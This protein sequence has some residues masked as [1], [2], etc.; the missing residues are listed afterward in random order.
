MSIIE[1]IIMTMLDAIE[2]IIISGKLISGNKVYDLEKGKILFYIKNILVLSIIV[3]IL[4]EF[5]PGK[6]SMVVISV[7]STVLI[8]FVLY[9]KK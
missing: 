2:Y 8:T 5:L 3:G 4:G 6:Y 9:R 1:S 7:I